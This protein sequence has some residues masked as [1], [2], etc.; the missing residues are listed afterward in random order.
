[1]DWAEDRVGAE[2]IL[3]A[4]AWRTMR[5]SGV[6]LLLNSDLPGSDW[7]I[8]YGLHSAVTRKDK[9]LE[10]PGGWYPDQ[11]LTPEEAIRGYTV[12]GA[13]AEFLDGVTGVIREGMRGDLTVMDIDPF[14][15]GETRP[16][17]LLQGRVLA[18]VV[19]GKVVYSSEH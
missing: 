16:D 7:D 9:S 12:W 17:A 1:M 13:W 14:E 5:R 4:Y 2:R 19:G 6:R 3:G 10:P 8:F 18:A 15:V 11:T